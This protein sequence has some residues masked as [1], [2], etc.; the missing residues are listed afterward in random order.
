MSAIEGGSSHH[1]RRFNTPSPPSAH[2]PEEIFE[3]VHVVMQISPTSP[4]PSP[5]PAPPL[6]EA[7][8]NSTASTS[9]DAAAAAAT[10]VPNLE[11]N[12][13][14]PPPEG[15]DYD[16]DDEYDSSEI[17]IFPSDD[18][19][20]YNQAVDMSMKREAVRIEMAQRNEANS[21]TMARLLQAERAMV[22]AFQPT[23]SPAVN[24]IRNDVLEEVARQFESLLE[25][26]VCL[27][28][29]RP[30][31]TTM[32]FCVNGH[33]FCGSC[34]MQLNTEK[35]ATCPV[36]RAP[37]VFF[38]HSNIFIKKMFNILGSFTVSKCEFE[39]C[40]YFAVGK[41]M[42][43]HERFCCYRPISCPRCKDWKIFPSIFSGDHNCFVVCEAIFSTPL[44]LNT[45]QWE[46]TI[47]VSSVLDLNTDEIFVRPDTRPILLRVYDDTD[48]R[49]YVYPFYDSYN[50]YL[51]FNV[52]W[53]ALRAHTDYT[54][55]RYKFR[56]KVSMSTK[57]GPMT[58]G[59]LTSPA[60]DCE[61]VSIFDFEGVRMRKSELMAWLGMGNFGSGQVCSECQS[62][63][64]IEKA[65]LHIFVEWVR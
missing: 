37:Q 44:R 56:I 24:R 35:D 22:Q 65:H 59:S 64:M 41:D 45:L 19:E 39:H 33:L 14:M 20:Y 62:T 7:R 40:P 18:D 53:L 42:F 16:N 25:C 43:I 4:S 51:V 34:T 31:T 23:D 5:P 1:H 8:S 61:Q 30:M 46:M 9:L 21:D 32:G 13:E 3:D 49:A 57:Y 15:S 6:V 52:R 63:N 48:F 29:P 11:A 26:P 12:E 58:K 50:R 28:V 2:L 38:S 54:V 36:C 10:E 47:D 27:E 55:K 60:F 17:D